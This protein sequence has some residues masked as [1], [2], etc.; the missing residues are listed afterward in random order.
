MGNNNVLLPRD[1]TISSS[2]LPAVLAAERELALASLNIA[3]FESPPWIKALLFVL[4]PCCGLEG[5]WWRLVKLLPFEQQANVRL[6]LTILE[7]RQS[8]QR[9]IER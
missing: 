2:E 3:A 4:T 1:D 6:Q 9:A 8:L 5:A 7:P